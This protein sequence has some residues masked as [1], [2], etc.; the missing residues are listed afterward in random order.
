MAK[1]PNPKVPKAAL[2]KMVSYKGVSGGDEKH[3][4][5]SAARE[6]GLMK[7]DFSKGF[8]TIVSGVNSLGASLNS[9]AL[10]MS[11]M[12][13]SMKTSVSKQIKN[14]NKVVKIQ[15]KALDD[16]KKREKQKIA[17]EAKRRKLEQRQNQEDNSE[18]PGLFKLI[19]K[20]F[21]ENTKK[22]FG[23]LFSGLVRFSTFLLKAAVGFAAL[24]WLAKNPDAIARL[25]KTFAAV[26]K[27]ILNV[28]SFLAGSAMDGLIKFLENPVSLKGL[29][30]AVQ[31]IASLSPLLVSIAFLGNPI[32]TIRG[33]AWV[34]STLGKSVAGM[35]KGIKGMG[36]MRI[37]SR[38][39]FAKLG[40]GLGT[41][42]AAAFA[43]SMAGGDTT[44]AIGAGVGAGS[45]QMI[46][47][48]IGNATNIPGMGMALGAAGGFLGGKAG[49]SVGKMLKPVTEPLGKFFKQVGD[50][51][52]AIMKPIGDAVGGLFE[53]LGEMMN[54]ILD[55]IGP[56]MPLITKILSIGVQTL[57]APLF[58]G[59]KALTAV[60][61]FFAP[62]GGKDKE[63]K[64]SDKKPQNNKKGTA[65]TDK[66]KKGDKPK[67]Y[68]DY[69]KEGVK[70][71]EIGP[72][73]FFFEF[74]DGST[75]TR[76]S[77]GSSNAPTVQQRFDGLVDAKI[78]DQKEQ[79]QRDKE[80]EKE[81][82]EFGK[83][84]HKSFPDKYN[85]DGTEVEQGKH[86]NNKKKRFG[87]F[88]GGGWINGPMSGYPVSLT[89][90]MTDFIGHGLEW[91]GQALN[92][93]S[94]VIP[95][96]TP[97]TRKDKGLTS[98]RMR[99]AMAG[100]YSMPPQ[101]MLGG[102]FGKKKPDQLV[103][104]Y[105]KENISN[106]NGNITSSKERIK[107]AIDVKHIH[108]HKQQILDQ[109]PKGTKIRD[110]L[111]GGKKINVSA[112]KL[113]KILYN[114]DA[115]KATQERI[116]MESE[117]AAKGAKFQSDKKDLQGAMYASVFDK[118]TGVKDNIGDFIN[119]AKLKFTEMKNQK[120]K[121]ANKVVTAPT[122]TEPPIVQ[123]G[124]GGS[125]QI[126]PIVRKKD[127]EAD[128]YLISRF[129]LV[130]EFNGDV[131]DLM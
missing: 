63:G 61:K 109:L 101:M 122:V 74:P 37:F 85:A 58:L 43:T 102:L 123:G 71:T 49:A 25:A 107:F 116:R 28:S 22:S 115:H 1:S 70:I 2:Y 48:A 33:V 47:A 117:K 46:G 83:R 26:G 56:H 95:F 8:A 50:T 106:V 121:D 41:G 78:R 75:S 36:K 130:S 87:L 39:K 20:E 67:Y 60:L 55:F 110:V 92:G 14:A 68:A 57:F 103:G 84:M 89:G 35:M 105:T 53:A 108:Q 23:S 38:N 112:L 44:E 3:T 7:K 129:G 34:I 13:A 69:M 72:N 98:K 82:L 128:P 62:G 9:I 79:E 81:K 51:F 99:Q 54:G 111:S 21:K 100:G 31:F 77:T 4:G 93:N 73:D 32:G 18:K 65:F 15:E 24:T 52:T 45:G 126:V 97:A 114:S 64:V 17:D 40:M 19:G 10:G 118:I 96:D 5:L 120:R 90:M 66:G 88:K 76:T 94:F 12:T 113:M 30:G 125:G 59:M 127:R 131:A 80:R 11:D 16:D 27:F 124:G 86:K 91:V 104:G 6:V 42:V 29:I 119:D